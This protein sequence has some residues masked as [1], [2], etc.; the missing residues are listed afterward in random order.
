MLHNIKAVLFDMDG[1]LVDSLWMWGAIDIEYLGK[2]G[3]AVPAENAPSTSKN[4]LGFP[5]KS[6]KSRRNGW[7][8]PGTNI[9][10]RCP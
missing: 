6:R 5:R 3:Y 4:A 2:H 7:R 9:P 10:M 1:T 8:W